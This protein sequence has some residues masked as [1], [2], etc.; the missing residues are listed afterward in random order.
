M[1]TS[2]DIEYNGKKISLTAAKVGPHYIG[3]FEIHGDPIVTDRGAD[4]MTEGAALDNAER[5]AKERV[6]LMGSKR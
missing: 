4:A 2:R 5:A 6:D 3:T 1:A